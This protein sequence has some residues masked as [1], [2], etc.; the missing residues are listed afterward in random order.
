[1]KKVVLVLLA[2]FLIGSFF[3]FRS[4]QL[5]K[6]HKVSQST[7]SSSTSKTASPFPRQT[8]DRKFLFVPYWGQTQE[9]IPNEFGDTLIYFGIAPGKDGI[10]KEE[11]GYLGLARFAA[12]AEGRD[13][14]LVLRM[15]DQDKSFSILKDEALQKKII[16]QSIALSK[17][18]GFKGVVLDLEITSLPFASITE[19]MDRFVSEFSKAAKK[20]NLSFFMMFFGDTFYRFRSY[21]VLRLVK[22]LD[23]TM[24]MAYDFH[25]AKGDPG[26]NFPLRGKETYGYDFS[27][28]INDFLNVIPKEK[29]VIVFGM[30]GYDWKVD[31]EGKPTEQ[32]EAVTLTVGKKQFLDQCLFQACVKKR[33]EQSAETMVHY[34]DKDENSHIVWFEDLESVEKKKEYLKEKGIN[35]VGFWAY[36]YF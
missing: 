3:A 12:I 24:I 10:D 28:M 19:Q 14:S 34:V 21:D 15:I 13:T 1:M 35:S 25:K 22:H 11:P 26:P 2:L 5:R 18:Y 16:G 32:A 20:E 31:K 29:L 30:F 36:S 7:L 17:Q 8:E 27:V 6:S 23:R 9:K 33:D 4:E